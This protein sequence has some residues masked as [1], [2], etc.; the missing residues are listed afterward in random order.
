MTMTVQHQGHHGIWLSSFLD[1][2]VDSNIMIMCDLESYI[3]PN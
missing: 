3:W 1:I 2:C